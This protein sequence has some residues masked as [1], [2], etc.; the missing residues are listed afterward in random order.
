M[1]S[2]VHSSLAG[3]Q[4]V[5]CDDWQRHAEV[6]STAL[7]PD[8]HHLV[9]FLNTLPTS[10]MP[11]MCYKLPEM[12]KHVDAV[13]A[14][15]QSSFLSHESESLVSICQEKLKWVSGEHA[16]QHFTASWRMDDVFLRQQL[17]EIRKAITQWQHSIV[18]QWEATGYRHSAEGAS[19]VSRQLPV[20]VHIDNNFVADALDSADLACILLHTCDHSSWAGVKQAIK[21]PGL[22]HLTVTR[23]ANAMS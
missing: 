11:I 13:L 7:H 19:H 8:V 15:P 22:H 5:L 21:A 23:Y 14:L 2:H 6:V 16:A 3:D 20:R 4:G 18:H 1:I 9:V 12:A 10:T 17:P